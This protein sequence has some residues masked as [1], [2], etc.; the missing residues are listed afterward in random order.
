MEVNEIVYEDEAATNQRNKTIAKLLDSYE[1]IDFDQ[2]ETYYIYTRQ[3]AT[4]I[5]V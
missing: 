4:N 1:K 2:P 5:N 3:Y